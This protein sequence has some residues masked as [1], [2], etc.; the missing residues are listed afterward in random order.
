MPRTI[1]ISRHRLR[2]VQLR[3]RDP[4]LRLFVYAVNRRYPTLQALSHEV[5]PAVQPNRP[6]N[7]DSAENRNAPMAE[8]GAMRLFFE[9]RARP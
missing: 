7:Y 8:S 9:H 4:L 1:I 5:M 2:F 6:V 3:A